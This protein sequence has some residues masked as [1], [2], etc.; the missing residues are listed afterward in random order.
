MIQDP[1]RRPGYLKIALVNQTGVVTNISPLELQDMVEKR[2]A[3]RLR[4][5]F[6]QTR[7]EVLKAV[8]VAYQEV[9]AELKLE[10]V[11]R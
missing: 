6:I 10:S 9:I 3:K 2:L 8:R 7:G 1:P 11:K 4:G 5:V